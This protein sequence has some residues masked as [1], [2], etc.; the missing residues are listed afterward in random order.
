MKKCKVFGRPAVPI[1]LP[2][3]GVEPQVVIAGRVVSSKDKRPSEKR[4]SLV[5]SYSAVRENTYTNDQVEQ[6]ASSLTAAGFRV[7]ISVLS[8]TG[9]TNV[10]FKRVRPNINALDSELFY[11]DKSKAQ[12]A[13]QIASQIV[14]TLG[15]KPV[16]V[17]GSTE[18]AD[19]ALALG[20]LSSIR[21]LVRRPSYHQKSCTRAR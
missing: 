5:V 19:S 6:V 11:C 15:P 18:G 20:T 13:L 1:G 10:G 4:I 12:E 14:N 7:F 9:R 2:S 17:E 3:L 21:V 16:L 8:I